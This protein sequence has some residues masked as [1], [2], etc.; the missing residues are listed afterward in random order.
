[1]QAEN[2]LKAKYAKLK[3]NLMQFKEL[4]REDCRDYETYTPYI[5]DREDDFG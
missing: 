4:Q 2:K 1:V 5:A 3:T